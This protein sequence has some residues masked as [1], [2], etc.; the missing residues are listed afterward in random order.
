MCVINLKNVFRFFYGPE[1]LWT[2][3]AIRLRSWTYRTFLLVEL[4]EALVVFTFLSVTIPRLKLICVSTPLRSL[5]VTYGRKC[6]YK[7]H[8][9][10]FGAA[11]LTKYTGD[12]VEKILMGWAR[13][14]H[15]EEVRCIQGFGEET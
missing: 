3:K 7:M 13:S 2:A 8:I 9:F 4:Y 6:V 11:L 10:F 12:Q 1:R 15:R 5:H 14:T